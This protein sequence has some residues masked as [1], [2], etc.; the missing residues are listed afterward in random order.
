MDQKKDKEIKLEISLFYFLRAIKKIIIFFYNYIHFIGVF[1][2]F[3]D[4]Y[5]N[6]KKMI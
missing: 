2:V 1:S 3:F 4:V 6:K 5:K